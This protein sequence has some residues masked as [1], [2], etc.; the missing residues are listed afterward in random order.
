MLRMVVGDMKGMKLAFVGAGA[1]TEALI[2]GMLQAKTV[3]PSQISVINRANPG[4]LEFLQGAYGV[5]AASGMA[6]AV[7]A[8]DILIL[9]VKP[10]DAHEALERAVPH[11]RGTPLILSLLAGI[12]THWIENVFA[13][14]LPVVRAMPNTS[15]AVLESATAIAPG[16]YAGGEHLSV[17]ERVFSAVGRVFRVE[18]AMLDVVTGLSG[19]GPAYFYFMVETLVDAGIEAGLDPETSRELVLQTLFGAAAMLRESGEDPA[20]LRQKVTSPGGT[21]MA[22]LR[23]FSERGFAQTLK[24]AVFRA[25]A[26][27][28]EMGEEY[29]RTDFVKTYK[30]P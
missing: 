28:R 14:P 2:R 3:R 15:C 27:S 24:E 11:V 30:M 16:R 22:A 19:S 23:V 18:E 12:P 29:A 7:E 13:R 5:Q 26:R 21:T 4:R 20:D 1:M 6:E 10:K 17:A 8:A 9:A 25:A